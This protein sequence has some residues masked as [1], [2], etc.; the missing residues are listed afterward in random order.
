MFNFE[1]LLPDFMLPRVVPYASR[2][3]N[4]LPGFFT[5]MGGTACT[6]VEGAGNNSYEG[7]ELGYEA[8]WAGVF[9][10]AGK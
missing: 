1:R 2:R 7:T 8:S 3:G 6:P 5:G 10:D 4:A 9:H